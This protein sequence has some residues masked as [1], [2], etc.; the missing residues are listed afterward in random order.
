MN[1]NKSPGP[2]GLQQVDEIKVKKYINKIGLKKATGL[3]NLSPKILRMTSDVLAKPITNI[4]NCMV[5][6]SVFPDVLKIARVTPVHKKNDTLTIENYRPVSILPAISKVF[7]RTIGEQL[8]EF[9]DHIFNPML[10]AYRQGYSCQSTLLALTESWRQALD[11]N[12]IAA[13]ILMDLSKAFDCV[14][15]MLLIEKLKAYGLDEKAVN[16]IQSYMSNHKQCVRVQNIHSSLF[17]ILKGVPQGSILGPIIFNVFLNDIFLFVEKA[18]LFNYADDNS[19][20]Y[21]H[22]NIENLKET[23][24]KESEGLIKWFHLNKLKANPEKFQAIVV[25]NMK[26]DA[27]TSFNIGNI[28]IESEETVKLLGVTVDSSLNFNCHIQNLCKKNL[29]TN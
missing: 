4:V 13:A 18:T 16:L 9:F 17:D 14:N 26:S 29:Q 7:E 3:D 23:L 20:S 11:E 2:E 19:L 12:K 1:N 27:E 8:V 10:S 6:T 21:S 25:G 28:K 15:P 24:E 22:R 5:K